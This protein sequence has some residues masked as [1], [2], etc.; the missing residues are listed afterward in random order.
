MNMIAIL[1]AAHWRWGNAIMDL[2]IEQLNVK[3]NPTLLEKWRVV[4]FGFFTI[5]GMFD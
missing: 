2:T 3:R 5:S 4:E 1:T